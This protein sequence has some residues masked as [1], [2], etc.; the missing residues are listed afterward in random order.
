[1]EM[2]KGYLNIL[3]VQTYYEMAGEGEKVLFIHG[4]DSDSRMWEKQFE[5][6]SKKFR[7]IRFD[8]RGFGK[9]PMPAGEFHI[10]EDINQIFEALN[11]E[12]AHLVGYSFGGTIAAPFSVYYPN[13]VQSLTL[14]GAGMIGY[15]WSPELSDYF[16]QFRQSWEEKDFT[17]MLKLLRWKSIYGPYREEAGLNEICE[18]LDQMYLHT[19]NNVVREGKPLSPGDTR[20]ELYKITAPSL[21]LVGEKD[22]QDYHSIADIYNQ[23]IPNSQKRIFPDAAHF[24]NL[25]NPV[26]FNQIVMDFISGINK[27]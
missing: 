7:A 9:T 24:L 19:L 15:E 1:M 8:L 10:L 22:F 17:T 13:R 4:V 16:K 20:G 6:F 21:I 2:V 25:E 26:L 14:V 12:K 18:L 23:C 27:E 3:G 5:A 11:I